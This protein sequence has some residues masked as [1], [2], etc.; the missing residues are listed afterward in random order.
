MKGRDHEPD[1]CVPRIVARTF[2]CLAI[3]CLLGMGAC[4]KDKKAGTTPG[5]SGS[6]SS[7][8][9]ELMGDGSTLPRASDG[10]GGSGSGGAGGTGGASGGQDGQNGGTATNGSTSDKPAEPPK[11]EPPDLD[12]GASAQKE[13]V[14]QHLKAARKAL[15]GPRSDPD[16]TIREAKAALA[17]D[18]SNI[19]AVVLI[20]HANYVKRLHD[21][22]EVMLDM[23]FKSNKKAQSNPGV[24][25]VYGL[26]YDQTNRPEQA[27]VAYQKAVELA[28][29]YQSALV[30]LGVH[31]LRN[32]NYPEAIAL[33]EKLTGELDLANAVTWTN[34]GSAYRGSSGDYP[35]DSGRRD[36]L[37]RKAETAYKR[38]LTVD[39]S[40]VKVYYNLGLLYLDADSFP[41]PDGKP[42][43]TLKRLERAKTYFDEYRAM[44]GADI[45]LVSD[46]LKQV[47]K[48]MK[49]EQKRRKSEDKKDK[50]SKKSGSDDDW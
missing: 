25:Y 16:A 35:A 5:S 34:L 33:Y 24:Y 23:M 19:D 2:A 43:D 10:A 41:G 44:S 9:T 46:R 7:E 27:M 13:R 6:V 29:T 36:E 20:A 21:T 3:A 8:D 31:Y 40:Y 42:M 17:V 12:I 22:A 48:L 39:K 11:I 50:K 49:R 38:A 4:N 26:I 32:H 45:D 47:E 14:S 37:L 15:E 1:A 28:P 30:N 18:A